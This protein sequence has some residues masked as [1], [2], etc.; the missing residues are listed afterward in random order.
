M[1]EYL[2]FTTVI[3]TRIPI[4]ETG[5][6]GNPEIISKFTTDKPQGTGTKFKNKKAQVKIA[7]TECIGEDFL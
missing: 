6:L 4:L 5:K 1:T 7:T 2:Y 3:S